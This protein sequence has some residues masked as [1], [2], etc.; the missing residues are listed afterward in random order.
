LIKTAFKIAIAL[1][2]INAAFH[3]GEVAWR[4]YQLKDA[5]QQLIIFGSQQHTNE[6]HNRIVE[7]AVELRIPL[8]PENVTIHRSGTRT[9]VDAAYTQPLEYFPNQV[10]PLDL[11]FSIE[12]YASNV[13][14]PEDPPT[15]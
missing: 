3:A 1:A 11:K 12:T 14:L 6:L 15:Q 4:Y 7:K 13:A 8:L 9:T 10:Y 5:A 2:V